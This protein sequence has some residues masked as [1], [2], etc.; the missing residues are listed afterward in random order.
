M[1]VGGSI[2]IIVSLSG[3]FGFAYGPNGEFGCT[4]TKCVG[5]GNIKGISASVMFGF[6]NNFDD[7]EGESVIKLYQ[8]SGRLFGGM[9]GTIKKSGKLIGYIGGAGGSISL[10][11]LLRLIRITVTVSICTTDMTLPVRDLHEISI[12]LPNF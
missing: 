10:S 2:G 7:I 9:F 4:W 3:E 5:L 6:Y 8:V 12:E 1:S 11:K